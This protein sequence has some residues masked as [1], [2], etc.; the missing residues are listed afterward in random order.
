MAV[1]VLDR[2]PVRG[3]FYGILFGLGL[4][5]VAI[6]QGWAALGTLTPFVIFLVGVV[7][8]TAWGFLGPAK[9]TKGPPPPEPVQVEATPPSRFD[10]FD[11]PPH[12]TGPITAETPIVGVFEREP[13]DEHPDREG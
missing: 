13:D 1:E 2:H 4:A 5:F 12:D 7:L 3:F 10:D 6:G 9:P 8:A 11:A